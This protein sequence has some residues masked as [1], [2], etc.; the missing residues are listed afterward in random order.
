MVKL[1]YDYVG[2]NDSC[3][4]IEEDFNNWTDANNTINDLKE[5]GDYCNFSIVEMED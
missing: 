3:T 5:I 2:E 4:G 1:I